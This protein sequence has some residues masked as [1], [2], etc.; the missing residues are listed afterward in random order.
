M[1]ST[2]LACGVRRIPRNGA[3]EQQGQGQEQED[4]AMAALKKAAAAQVLVEKSS[5][6]T[7]AR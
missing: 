4:P 6:D 3:P 7:G 5:C 1:V 2:L